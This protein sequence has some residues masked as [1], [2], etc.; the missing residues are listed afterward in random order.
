MISGSKRGCRYTKQLSQPSKRRLCQINATLAPC[1]TIFTNS[2]QIRAD[3]K[4]AAGQV[5]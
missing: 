3:L 2:R 1:E 5:I 4:S